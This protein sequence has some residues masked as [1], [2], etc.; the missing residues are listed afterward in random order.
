[1]LKVAVMSLVWSCS[2]PLRGYRHALASQAVRA[3]ERVEP[4]VAFRPKLTTPQN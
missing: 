4:Y 2:R 1:M 3:A